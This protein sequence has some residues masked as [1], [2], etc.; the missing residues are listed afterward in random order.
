MVRVHVYTGDGEGKTL[1]A[2]GL[3]IRAAGHNLKS[4]IIQFMKGRKDIGEYKALKKCPFVK[5]KQFGRPGFVDLQN[6]KAEDIKLGEKGMLFAKKAISEK[7]RVLVLD[8][9]NLAVSIGLVNKYDV[10][11]LIDN[12][13]E[14]LLLILTGRNAPEEF[15]DKADL[16]TVMN[17]V[18][19]PFKKGIKAVEGI[20]Y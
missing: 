8:E 4:T 2:V 3:I 18:K 14:E 6:P 7:I 11:E 20:E 5:I 9:I 1:T 16:V 17:D 12:A 15:I 13:P 10:L 19:H